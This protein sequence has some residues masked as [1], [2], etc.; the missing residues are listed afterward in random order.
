MNFG[1]P[2]WSLITN[3][4]TVIN[5]TLTNEFIFGSSK[6]H[7]NIDPVD[8]TFDRGL[9]WTQLYDAVPGCRPTR[10]DPELAI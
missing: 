9:A 1:N 2:G 4:T 6:N 7:L 5:P 8:N 10:P 3:V